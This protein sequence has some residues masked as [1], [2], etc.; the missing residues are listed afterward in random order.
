VSNDMRATRDALESRMFPVNY[1]LQDLL[2]NNSTT[3]VSTI[4]TARNGVRWNVTI[5]KDNGGSIY[6]GNGRIGAAAPFDD[7]LASNGVIHSID[8][9]SIN[10]TSDL[11]PPILPTA[12]PSSSPST[13]NN[14]RNKSHPPTLASSTL[15]PPSI[16]SNRPTAP[17]SSSPSTNNNTHSKSHPPTLASSTLAPTSITSIAASHNSSTTDSPVA[18]TSPFTSIAPSS[19]TNTTASQFDPVVTPP[20]PSSSSASS[21]SSP[22]ANSQDTMILV[23]GLLGLAMLA[24]FAFGVMMMLMKSTTTHHDHH[25]AKGLLPVHQHHHHHHHKINKQ[26]DDMT[27]NSV[28]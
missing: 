3:T 21:S 10:V 12:P 18:T 19:Q 1:Y 16:T 22:D 7:Q 25:T 24:A 17:P 28:S 26:L 11:V 8:R 6:V 14:T 5:V 27:H 2:Q 15:A 23:F 13:N 9:F 4:W 20:A